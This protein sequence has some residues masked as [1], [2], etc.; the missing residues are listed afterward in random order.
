MTPFFGCTRSTRAAWLAASAMALAAAASLIRAD[1]R[2]AAHL[3]QRTITFD[4]LVPRCMVLEQCWDATGMD[5]QERVYIGFTARR[6][7]GRED[8]ALFRYDPGTGDRRFLGTFM[9]A[10]QAA[11]NLAAGEEIPKGH[12]HLIELQGKMYM[13]SQG[14]HDFKDAIDDLPHF[15]GS[16]L[17]ALDLATDTLEDVS[18]SLPGGVLTSHTGIIA[19]SAVPGQTLLAGLEHP[20]SNIVLFDYGSGRAGKVVPGIPWRQ[21]NPLSREIVATKQG[22]IYT[23]R[24]TEEPEQRTQTHEV[25]S[26]DLETGLNQPT[27]YSLTGGFWNGQSWSRDG[28]TVYLSTVNG[29]L[30]RLDTASG[31]ITSLG[32]LLPRAEY[33]AGERIDQLYGITLSLDEQ[34]I[35]GVPRRSRSREADL[36]AYE[37]ATGRVSLVGAL[38]PAIYSGS[39]V[40]DSR[41]NIYLARFGDD[42]SWQGKTGLSVVHLR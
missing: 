31:A 22:R 14:F 34:T 24:G 33:D 8:F 1:A 13:G 40:R 36:Y 27:A 6:D 37:I 10:S 11:G 9:E 42:H 20:T 5:R 2:D 18:R 21:G 41:G 23:Y 35:Y 15:R 12:T 3:M 7:D 30:Y 19:L 29:E 32:P 4:D 38:E 25:W 39:H 17:Y 26:Y 28:E 16:H